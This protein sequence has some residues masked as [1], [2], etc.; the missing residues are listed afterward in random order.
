MAKKQE[1]KQEQRQEQKQSKP[2]YTVRKWAKTKKGAGTML[3]LSAMVGDEWQNINAYVP[4]EVNV[5]ED[6]V[7]IDAF[8]RIK[9]NE[10]TGKK[11]AIVFI[12]V[13]DEYKPKLEPSAKTS[14]T[15]EDVDSP[16]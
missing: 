14:E 1:Q 6:R 11:C 4:T 10:K 9:T 16:F 3:R 13:E 8:A 7:G 2:L 5:K 12:P 15:L